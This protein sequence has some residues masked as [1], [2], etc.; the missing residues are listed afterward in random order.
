MLQKLPLLFLLMPVF[1][2]ALCV[3]EWAHAWVASRRGDPTPVLAGRL[4]L[5][6]WAHWDLVGTLLLPA[7]CILSGIPAFGWAK[8]VPIDARHF[9]NPR[10][11]TALVAAAGPFSNFCMAA[12]GAVC[13]S[14]LHPMPVSET[15]PQWLA[16]LV[17]IGEV[18]FAMFIQ[19]NLVLAFFNLLP[20]PPLDGFMIVQSVLPV[21]A[22]RVFHR[23]APFSILLLVGIW[24][25]G[26]L[27]FLS[28]PVSWTFDQLIHWIVL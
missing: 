1:L 7:A 25:M 22:I 14:F 2:V 3:H 23:V 8:P 27:K 10:L 28:I 18:G 21:R 20:I 17:S 6:P 11:D 13:L 19:L 9:R 24:A 16:A 26:G 4:S 12:L 15:A 5:L